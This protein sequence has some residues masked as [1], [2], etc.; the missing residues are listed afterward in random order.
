MEPRTN[1]DNTL[2]EPSD[3]A[4]C[5]IHMAYKT[6][7]GKCPHCGDDAADRAGRKE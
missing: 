3:D 5:T 7:K 2:D 4:L 6:M 1:Y